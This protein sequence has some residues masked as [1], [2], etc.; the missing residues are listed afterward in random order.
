MALPDANACPSP[1]WAAPAPAE[2]SACP[3]PRR[4]PTAPAGEAAHTPPGRAATA[5]V[6]ASHMR[7]QRHCD[8]REEGRLLA[9]AEYTLHFPVSVVC[10]AEG[11]EAGT[12]PGERAWPAWDQ[13]ER[14][15]GLESCRSPHMAHREGQR[16]PRRCRQGSHR[17]SSSAGHCHGCAR[18]CNRCGQIRRRGNRQLRRSRRLRVWRGSSLGDDSA[19]SRDTCRQSS[20]QS[21]GR[22]GRT[23]SPCG[24]NECRKP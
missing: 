6:E 10:E 24:T 7:P 11:A 23:G 8:G 14:Q 2:A 22:S 13:G 15:R 18:W 1:G 12:L 20:G 17:R 9:L 4:A 16:Q 21:G 3:S 19:E 5:P